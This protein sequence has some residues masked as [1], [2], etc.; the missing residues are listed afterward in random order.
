MTYSEC[1]E[2]VSELVGNATL[3]HPLIIAIDGRSASGKTTFADEINQRFGIPIIHTDDYCRPRNEF[4]DLDISEFDG[5]FDIA[6]FKS[7][8]IDGVKSGDSFEIGIFDC[9]K[10]RIVKTVGIPFSKCYL[11]EGAYSHNPHLGDYAT[12]KLFFDINESLQ[13]ERIVLRNGVDGSER[14]VSVWIPAEER[15]IEHYGVDK[16]CDY[17]INI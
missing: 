11:V 14:Y 1:M 13:R 5:N 4:G 15:Y 17:Y 3:E 7:E 9:K 6:R 2:F 16:N 8:V 12:V 10:G